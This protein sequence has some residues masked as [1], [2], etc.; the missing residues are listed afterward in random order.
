MTVSDFLRTNRYSD[1]FAEHYLLPVGSA[2]WS[3]PPATFAEF[4]VRFIVEFYKNHGLL[5]LRD[6]PVWKVIRGGSHQYVSALARRFRGRIRLNTTIDHVVRLPDRVKI[7]P[8]GLPEESFD[9]VIFACHSDQAL[10]ILGYDADPIERQVL[11][12]FPYEPNT[13]VLHTDTS[14][15]PRRRRAWASWNYHIPESSSNGATFT[16]NMNM[17]QHIQSN[18]VFCVTL[19]ECDAIDERKVIRR[20]HYSHPVYT[21]GRAEAQ[22]RHG[23]LIRANRTSFCGAYWGNGFHEDGVNSALAVCSAF[24]S[25]SAARV[26]EVGAHG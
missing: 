20:F 7:F 2:I 3:C 25:H 5:S 9:E 13:A 12:Q 19:N 21:I 8:R 16:Y 6:R 18:R 14:L 4:P 11:S 17:L 1:V 22:K 10:A 26:Q 23:E 15:L 24:G